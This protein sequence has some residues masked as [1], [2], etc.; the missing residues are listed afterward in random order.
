MEIRRKIKRLLVSQT[1]KAFHYQIAINIPDYIQ[2]QNRTTNIIHG[3]SEMYKHQRNTYKYSFFPPTIKDWN[4][5]PLKL[6]NID[7]VEAF[8]NSL[9]SYLTKYKNNV[10]CKKHCF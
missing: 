1:D 10:T 9:T 3:Y 7:D 5:L 4:S 6:L 2:Q 8:K